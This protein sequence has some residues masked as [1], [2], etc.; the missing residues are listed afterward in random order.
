[1]AQVVMA[2]LQNELQRSGKTRL[3][4]VILVDGHMTFINRV[5][6]SIEIF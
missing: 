6:S 5:K 2:T 3:D 1:M 4:H